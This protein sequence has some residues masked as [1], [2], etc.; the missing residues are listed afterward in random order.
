MWRSSSFA[1][2]VAGLTAPNVGEPASG[3]GRI[4]KMEGDRVATYRDGHGVGAC[5][6]PEVHAP[7]LPG[8]FQHGERRG[9]APATDLNSTSAL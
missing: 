1:D 7:W 8:C 6:L 5:A 2:R 4:V 9:T 3:E